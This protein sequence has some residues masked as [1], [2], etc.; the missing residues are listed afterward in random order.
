M[1]ELSLACPL[2]P[3]S[4][5]N[6]SRV[7]LS[8]H[9]FIISFVIV[10]RR[11]EI[12]LCSHQPPHRKKVAV[13]EAP[14][15]EQK[16]RPFLQRSGVLLVHPQQRRQPRRLP[17]WLLDFGLDLALE[18]GYVEQQLQGGGSTAVERSRNSAA[19]AW[20]DTRTRFDVLRH[21]LSAHVKRRLVCVDPT[22]SRI[23]AHPTRKLKL[24]ERGNQSS[25]A[26]PEEM[27]RR[28]RR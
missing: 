7:F 22:E 11:I 20:Q 26:E 6:S 21:Y 14:P 1:C 8:R 17:R 23:I 28:G 19:L 27:L 9:Y 25:F 16:V 2:D 12:I 3:L 4:R 15:G 10:F 13:H 24:N 18:G 5:P